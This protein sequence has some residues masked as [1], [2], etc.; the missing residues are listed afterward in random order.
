MGGRH[1]D[2]GSSR[3]L[4]DLVVMV[5]GIGVV[6]VLVFGGLWL[7]AQVGGDDDAV[8]ATTSSTTSTTAAPVTTAAPTTTEAD[9]TTTVS[10]TST[11]TASTTSTVP[12][13]DPSEVTVQVFNAE[14][15]AGLAGSVSSE[16]A[17]AGYVVLTALDYPDLLDTSRIFHREGFGPE[18]QE[19][20][21]RFPDAQVEP[22][23][24]DLDTEADVAVVLGAS[25]QG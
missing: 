20:A 11:T 8:A 12:A 19:L 18:A 5:V 10:S 17:A 24:A 14:G 3:F 6:A 1:V 9:T 7:I 25:Y 23:P 15:T 2:P 13:R 22:M 21:G 16:L 4:R